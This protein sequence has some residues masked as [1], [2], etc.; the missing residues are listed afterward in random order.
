MAIDIS[1]T[2]I[3]KVDKCITFENTETLKS[4]LFDNQN[5]IQKLE[6][7]S[8]PGASQCA[9]TMRSTQADL[10]HR[11]AEG[12]SPSAFLHLSPQDW[13]NRRGLKQ[14]HSWLSPRTI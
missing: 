8:V 4:W 11:R 1:Y 3:D 5:Q 2:L 13:G 12:R 14:D 6:I 9:P 10:R 7:P